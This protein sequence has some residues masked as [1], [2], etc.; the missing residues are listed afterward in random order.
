[1]IADAITERVVVAMLVLA[2]AQHIMSNTRFIGRSLLLHSLADQQFIQV[3]KRV[4]QASFFA[5]AGAWRVLVDRPL[6][7]GVRGNDAWALSRRLRAWFRL[8]FGQHEDRGWVFCNS[9]Q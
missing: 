8:G 2:A 9:T 3:C 6:L 5:G 7:T 4:N 1:M